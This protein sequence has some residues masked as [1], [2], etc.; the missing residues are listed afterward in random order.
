VSKSVRLPVDRFMSVRGLEEHTLS[1]RI[2]VQDSRRPGPVALTPLH[3]IVRRIV[4]SRLLCTGWTL[5]SE[6]PRV[7]NYRT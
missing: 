4:R 5:L 7:L 3:R 1:V 2:Q 6:L